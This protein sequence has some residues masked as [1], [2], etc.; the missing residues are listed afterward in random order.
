MKSFP[1]EEIPPSGYFSKTA[2]IDNQFIIA[3][4]ETP[5]TG[6]LVSALNEWGF[7][8][9]FSEGEPGDHYK[10]DDEMPENPDTEVDSRSMTEDSE[11]IK[12]AEKFYASF[13]QYTET[14]F[15]DVAMKKKLKQN[16]LMEKIKTVCGIVKEEHRYLMRTRQHAEQPTGKNYLISHSVRTTVISL[17]IGNYLKFPQH[18]LIEL[19]TAALLHDIGMITLPPELYLSGRTF[20]EQE[21][22]MIYIHPI[23]GYKILKTLNFPLA[24][25]TAALEHHERENG[26]GY[27]QNLIRDEI[28]LY[29][30]IIAVACSYEA[31]LAKRSHKEAKDGYSGMLE[32]LKNEGKK[33]D[34]NII[35]A[36]VYSL[37]IY[38][39]GMHVLLSNKKK[40]QVVD[41]NP[42]NPRYPVVQ[43]TGELM[44]NGKKII[45]QTFA[46][47]L[48]IVRP[49]TRDEV[50]E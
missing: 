14:L 22:K 7:T 16:L 13:M 15:D 10:S 47:G 30:K 6:E 42:E 44:P 36:L 29:G 46:K 38:P 33:Y 26:S 3:A 25:C 24:V 21:K 34:D 45:I 2:Y 37:S 12:K 18:R 5:F 43:I 28:S 4:P 20:T 17:I 35:R 19:G 50:G 27:P 41:V 11:K 23:Q 49:L 31:L 39:V 40:G 9:V 32:L 1:I 48:S 8:E